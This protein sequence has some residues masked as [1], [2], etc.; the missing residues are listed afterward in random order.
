MKITKQKLK[1]IILEEITKEVKHT[2]YTAKMKPIHFLELTTP[3]QE[4]DFYGDF[5]NHLKNLNIKDIALVKEEFLKMQP[6]VENNVAH[7]VVSKAINYYNKKEFIEAGIPSLTLIIKAVPY[8]IGHEGRT[9]SFRNILFNFLNGKNQKDMEINLIIS[10][11]S[12]Y[13]LEYF[14]DKFNKQGDAW[15]TGQVLAGEKCGVVR[16]KNIKDIKP[17]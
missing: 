1:Q 3:K 8:T 15:I 4:F 2:N 10:P 7:Q 11:E 6:D 13:S 17:I 16:L 9:R 14:I 12:A 5:I